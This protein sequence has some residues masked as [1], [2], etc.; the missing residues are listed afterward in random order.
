MPSAP[1]QNETC[2]AANDINPIL[3][4]PKVRGLK[5][6][7]ILGIFAT[8]VVLLKRVI[9]FILRVSKNLYLAE[10]TGQ[11]KYRKAF[12]PPK[13]PLYLWMFQDSSSWQE[14]LLW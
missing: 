13:V 6:A 5:R 11:S 14:K 9:G 7:A 4:K 2:G 3:D 1:L 12:I 8:M 10:K